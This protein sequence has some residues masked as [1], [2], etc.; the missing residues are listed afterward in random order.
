MLFPQNKFMNFGVRNRKRSPKCLDIEK[1]LGK[2]EA[3]SEHNLIFE[4]SNKSIIFFQVSKHPLR[5][6]QVLF[7]VNIFCQAECEKVT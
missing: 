6:K 3:G 2:V 1:L 7:M 4:R 5:L